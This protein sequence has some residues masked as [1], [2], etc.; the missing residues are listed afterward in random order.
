MVRDNLSDDVAMNYTF[1]TVNNA[2]GMGSSTNSL[3]SS[4]PNNIEFRDDWISCM[5]SVLNGFLLMDDNWWIGL[6]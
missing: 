6:M 5:V 1:A 3:M 2:L 4:L